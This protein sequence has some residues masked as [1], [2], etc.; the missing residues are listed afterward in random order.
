MHTY[1]IQESLH[2]LREAMTTKEKR[3]QADRRRKGNASLTGK[4]G[5]GP[6][7]GER[8]RQKKRYVRERFGVDDDTCT[9]DRSCI[10]LSAARRSPSRTT[11]TRSGK[12]RWPPW[13]NSCVGCGVCGEVAHAAVLCPSF[14]KADIVYNPSLVDRSLAARAFR[15]DRRTAGIPGTAPCGGWR[16]EHNG[17]TAQDRHP[18]HGRAGRRRARQLADRGGGTIG[19]AGA[20]HPR[21]PVSHSVPGPPCT[22]WK[23]SLSRKVRKLRPSWRSCPV[24]GH[25]DVVIAGELAEAGRAVLRGLVTRERTTLIASTHRDFAIDEK[26]AMGDGR[27]DAERLRALIERGASRFIGFDM[28]AVAEETESVI[29]SVLLGAVAGTGI[30][31]FG[32]E[33]CAEVIRAMGVA[34]DANLRAFEAGYS[35]AGAGPGP[36]ISDSAASARPSAESGQ[37]QTTD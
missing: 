31:P 25:V 19:M 4:G 36:E 11:R 18:G 30:T 23:S 27:V 15:G 37:V 7:S 20:V 9:G 29:S 12:T 2:A 21:C 28:A 3:A 32:K 14:Y 6:G 22:T 5:S 26:S 10:R 35:Q 1:R 24:P 17:N 34:V 8:L 33:A 13:S 16:S